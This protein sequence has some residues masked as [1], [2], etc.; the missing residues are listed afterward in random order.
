M[1]VYFVNIFRYISLNNNMQIQCLISKKSWVTDK[2]KL[3][4]QD[5]LRKFC[6]KIYFVNSHTKLKK[7][8]DVNF[9]LTY[10]EKIPNK[11]LFKSKYNIIVHGSNLPK[12]RGMSPVSW[13][14]LKGINE[15]VFI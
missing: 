11:S 3:I 5:K 1:F 8:Y 10:K 14:L 12:G 13:Q 9:I 7:N 2:H 6:K 4:I 15:I